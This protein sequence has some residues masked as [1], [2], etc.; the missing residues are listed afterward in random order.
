MRRAG[1]Q[2]R[3]VEMNRAE[4]LETRGGSSLAAALIRASTKFDLRLAGLVYTGHW[5]RPEE[6]EASKEQSARRRQSAPGVCFESTFI[7]YKWRNQSA[8]RPVVAPGR[9]AATATRPSRP[10]R[11]K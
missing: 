3:A 5:S 6:L 7:A 2:V 1:G 10:R 8:G 4:S 11:H 9:A